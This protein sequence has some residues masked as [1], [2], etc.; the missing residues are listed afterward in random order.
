M[1]SL[2]GFYDPGTFCGH[3]N[4]GKRGICW[5]IYY[6]R[7]IEGVKDCAMAAALQLT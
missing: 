6:F 3:L 2:L 5:S 7:L 4:L 1:K